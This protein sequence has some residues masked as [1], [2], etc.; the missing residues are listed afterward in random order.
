[1]LLAHQSRDAI[2]RLVRQLDRRAGVT[3]DLD[4]FWDGLQEIRAAGF[5]W[6][7]N[8]VTEGAGTM[9]VLA[10]KMADGRATVLGVAGPLSRLEPNRERLLAS[11][12]TI[13][14]PPAAAP[15]NSRL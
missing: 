2:A 1:M 10:P 4:A 14:G 3:L 11:L 12:R 8:Q 9:A 5:A 7:A 15:K 6:S 13:V